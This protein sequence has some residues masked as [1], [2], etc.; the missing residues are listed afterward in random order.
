MKPICEADGHIQLQLVLALLAY[1]FFS[2][3]SLE[4]SSWLH[5]PSRPLEMGSAIKNFLERLP[6]AT[7]T[8]MMLT[9]IIKAIVY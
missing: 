8:R 3:C 4:Y 7:R 6:L 5:L 9:S 1:W 2:V